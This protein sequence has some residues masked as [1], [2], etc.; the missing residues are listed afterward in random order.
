[1]SLL[2]GLMDECFISE[3]KKMTKEKAVNLAER[4]RILY[5]QMPKTYTSKSDQNWFYKSYAAICAKEIVESIKE[6]DNVGFLL[7]VLQA[8]REGAIDASCEANSDEVNFMFSVM[9][10][11]TTDF[12]DLY[13]I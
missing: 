9:A 10:D 4:H 11:V 12:I 8:G 7:D 2:G 13:L 3:R 5:Y 1:M 6:L